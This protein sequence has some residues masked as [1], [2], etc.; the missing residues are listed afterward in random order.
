MC[1]LI[2]ARFVASCVVCSELAPEMLVFG[3]HVFSRSVAIRLP[4]P[5]ARRLACVMA[6]PAPATTVRRVHSRNTPLSL[7]VILARCFAT[8][9]PPLQPLAPPQPELKRA[10]AAPARVEP[11][12]LDRE[13]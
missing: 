3:R 11:R 9:T 13:A 5:P 2:V 6:T 1:V 10:A 12:V 7:S 8:Q 4:V